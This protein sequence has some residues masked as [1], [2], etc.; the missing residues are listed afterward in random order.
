MLQNI[1]RPSGNIED[2][3]RLV[4]VG[5]YRYI[6]HP[7][8]SSLLFLGWGAFFKD[9]SWMG[10]ALVL[11]ATASLIITAKVEERENIRKFGDDYTQYLNVTKMF[12]P[13]VF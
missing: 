2:T 12:V 7:M 6:R 4:E 10:F 13:F 9:P 5:A 11:I 3:T 8:Y 1:G